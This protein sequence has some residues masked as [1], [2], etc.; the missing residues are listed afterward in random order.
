MITIEEINSYDKASSLKDR[1]DKLIDEAG[2]DISL[3]FDFTASL[4]EAHL[5]KKDIILLVARDDND[6]IG[7]F[8]LVICKKRF[9]G[10]VPVTTIGPLSNIFCFH[11]N[12]MCKARVDECF[13]AVL[14]HLSKRHPKWDVFEINNACEDSNIMGI[15]KQ[16][17]FK[18]LLR[19]DG[20]DAPYVKLEGSWDE[21]INKKSGNFRHNLRRKE[22]AFQEGG[23]S[24]I[25]ELRSPGDVDAILKKMY[26]IEKESW[27]EKADISIA[28][29]E[30]QRRFYESYLK[31]TASADRLLA[32]FLQIADEDIAFMLHIL[33]RRICFQLK[34]AYKDKF[35]E[36]SPGFVS[37]KYMVKKLF[38]MGFEEYDFLIGNPRW[39]Q[40]WATGARKTFNFYIYNNNRFYSN[41]IYRIKTMILLLRIWK[42]NS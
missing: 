3:S 2:F 15:I 34:M 22:E 13:K 8:P 30:K 17:H 25:M 21:Y 35:K 4:W 9:F 26:E 31:K 41:C 40:E 12:F 6:I 38:D 11:N 32:T 42:Q 33:H 5:D 1:W 10:A 39:K 20:E 19:F 14:N 16:D 24:R 37:N 29:D 36:R 7:I 27:K 28:L 18:D 23:N